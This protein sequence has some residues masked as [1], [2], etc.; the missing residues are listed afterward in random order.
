MNTMMGKDGTVE[1]HKLY[2]D[3][4]WVAPHSKTYIAVENPANEELLGYVSDAD[5]EDV[6]KALQSSDAAQVNWQSIPILKRAEYVTTLIEKLRSQQPYFATLLAKEQGKTYQE[7]LGEV[8]DTI[9][10][11]QYAVESAKHIKSD[12]MPVMDKDEAFV[13][14][15]VPYGVTVALCAWNYPLALVGRKLGPALITGNTMIIKPHELTPLATT[16]FF[17]LV[18]EVGFPP[19]VVNLITGNG[20]EAGNL[21][22]SSPIT[23]LISVT[24][25]V[26]AGQA[27]YKAASGHIAGLVLELG[28]KAPFI[29]LKD[30][31]I[32]KAVDAAIVSRYSNCGQVCTCCD[33]IFVQNEVAEEFTEKL[34]KK[35]A[36]IKV[37]DPFDPTTTMGPKVSRSDWEKIDAVVQK[38]IAEGAVL[39][40]GGKRPE[41]EQFVKGH[42]Y[43][44]TV[45]TGVTKDMTAAKDEIF[46][47]VLPIIRIKDFDE[48]VHITNAS[49]FG[50]ACYLF[51][52]DY[53]IMIEASEVLQVGT[54]FINKQIFGYVHGFHSGHK[55][56]GLNGEDGE[57][58]L[59]AFM[60]KRALYINYSK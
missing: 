38:T 47:P 3:G 30:A 9:G 26:G 41:G 22:V 21:L 39:A 50:L 55:L 42:W 40:A 56:S 10:Y 20:T 19:G 28:G 44:P 13:I 60:Q 12:I 37:G 7:A 8:A 45:L 15:K 16:E 48:A 27:I 32:D 17:Q 24:G 59:D 14:K 57:Y 5:S 49:P 51:T 29:V 46:G 4:K 35:V 33:M 11:M 18:D 23:K 58:G 36:K 31:N 25:S 34:L 52:E 43:E 54:V 1:Y 53:R 2:I 6:L